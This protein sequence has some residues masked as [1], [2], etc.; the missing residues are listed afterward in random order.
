MTAIIAKSLN[1]FKKEMVEGFTGIKEY[2]KKEVK[3]IENL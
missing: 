2:M 1:A 3:K